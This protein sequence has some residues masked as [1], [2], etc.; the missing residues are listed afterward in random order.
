MATLVGTL[1]AAP[2][3]SSCSCC[4]SGKCILAA[5]GCDHGP[6][7]ASRLTACCIADAEPS[8][9]PAGPGSPD[10]ESAILSGSPAPPPAPPPV[11]R[12]R[13]ALHP[14]ALSATGPEIA[15]AR[16][17]VEGAVP[18]ARYDTYRRI[19]ASLE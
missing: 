3:G 13:L 18:A 12:P 1:P 19:W 4:E 6:A 2:P 10:L 15:T 11:W 14:P 9:T 7:E 5:G 16:R 8:G 17:I